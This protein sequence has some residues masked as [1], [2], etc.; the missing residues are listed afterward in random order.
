MFATSQEHLLAEMERI[1]LLIRSRVAKTRELHLGDERFSGLYIS[2]EEIDRIL[3]HPQG[4]PNWVLE[5]AEE[6]DEQLKAQLNR[7]RSEIGER[8]QASVKQGVALRLFHLAQTCRLDSFDVDCLLIC[9][10]PEIDL[11][12]GQIYAYLQDD[13]T[14]KRPTVDLT[15]NLLCSREK[16]V[17]R[18][19]F[20][21]EAPLQRHR[22]I[23]VFEEP[24]LSQAPL[25]GKCLKL[26]DRVTSY[27]LGADAI[28]AKIRS[29]TRRL[30]PNVDARA[31]F[32]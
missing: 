12:Y 9:L 24:L 2:D 16:L 6:R 30:I 13:V 29:Y 28:D 27:L 21:S 32:T 7:L 31:M 19:R 17:Y 26:D 14:R 18:D 23:E 10:A 5:P 1:D 15:L 22:L 20:S 11:R 3:A 8:T 25:L 4:M